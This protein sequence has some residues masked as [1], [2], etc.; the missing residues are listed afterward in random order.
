MRMVLA[1]LRRNILTDKHADNL[2]RGDTGAPYC[3]TLASLRIQAQL[4]G[5]A[6]V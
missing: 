2:F 5:I 1:A 6:K 3:D 4:P